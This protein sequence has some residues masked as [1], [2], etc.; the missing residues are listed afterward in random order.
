[1]KVLGIVWVGTRSDRFFDMASFFERTLGLTQSTSSDGFNEYMLPNAD[2]VALIS[3]SDESSGELTTGP[4]PGFLVSDI[5]AAVDELRAAGIE[6]IGE[7]QRHGSYSW[8]HFRAPDG[9][10][11][12]L[13]EDRRRLGS[14]G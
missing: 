4:V 9:N 10:V 13:V 2:R 11:Y 1:V 14:V 12:E 5:S 7:L 3:S 8:Q 6:L